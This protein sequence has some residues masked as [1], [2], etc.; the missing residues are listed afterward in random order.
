MTN[1]NNQCYSIIEHD[2]HF[3]FLFLDMGGKIMHISEGV[4][5]APILITG[6]V[7]AASGVYVGLKKIKDEDIP[8]IAVVSA[9]L[10]VASLIHIPLGPTS[11]HLILNGIAG[12]L[13]G[14]AII[15]S[16]LIVLFLQS[17]LFQFG[18]ITALGVNT[19]I[20][21]LPGVIVYYLFRFFFKRT[22]NSLFLSVISFLCGMISIL[23]SALILALSLF[24]TNESFFQIARL[25]VISH[26]PVIIIEGIMT[27]FTI[28]FIRKVKPEILKEEI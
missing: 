2:N 6:G 11:V 7:V 25:N 18:G 20:L 24:Y 15:P 23:L 4:L 16:F 17:I 1:E 9:A 14:W 10:F 27:I 8:K 5:T 26:L 21:A 22:N 3:R 12:I 28:N 19:L 13:L